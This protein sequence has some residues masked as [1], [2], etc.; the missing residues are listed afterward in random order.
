MFKLYQISNKYIIIVNS[1]LV[2]M[3]IVT[4][5]V[6]SFPI[7]Y[8]RF[9]FCG[10]SQS[11]SCVF[12]KITEAYCCITG[13]LHSHTKTV[14]YH[15]CIWCL[16]VF[17]SSFVET[18]LFNLAPGLL[19]TD[20]WPAASSLLSNTWWGIQPVCIITCPPS[21]SF[22]YIKALLTAS[23]RCASN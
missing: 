5:N 10:V 6:I 4:I 17:T 7:M 13:L 18:E 11:C 12:G 3:L 23:P 9:V 15:M 21:V 2:A 14:D 22:C 16:C 20:V 19:V 8:C 1:T